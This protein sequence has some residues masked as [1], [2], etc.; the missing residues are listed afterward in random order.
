MQL[1]KMIL[2]AAAGALAF[3]GVLT[4][5]AEASQPVIR[6]VVY[7]GP[8]RLHVAQNLAFV[9]EFQ[10]RFYVGAR[11]ALNLSNFSGETSNETDPSMVTVSESRSF[12]MK[13]GFD[14]SAGYRWAED[15]RAEINY[16]YTGRYN[17][18]TQDHSFELSTQYVMANVL[19]SFWRGQDANAFVG[20]GGG[21]AMVRTH[22]SGGFFQPIG[23]ETQTTNTW[24]AQFILGIEQALSP[25]FYLGA[26]Y[27]LMYTGGVSRR[28]ENTAAVGPGLA[29]GDILVEDISGIL[30]NS[31]MLGIRL[32]F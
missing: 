17:F 28:L 22:L 4:F 12:E 5:S 6:G 13:M 21:L 14:V 15:W 30:T 10:P 23:H 1:R 2:V 3:G 29:V 32:E 18:S 11:G 7:G 24:A 20:L 27:R 25:G 19:H 8:E 26:Q 9:T 16:G 31:F